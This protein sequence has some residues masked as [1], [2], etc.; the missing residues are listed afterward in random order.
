MHMAKIALDSRHHFAR[1]V[2]AGIAPARGDGVRLSGE[3]DPLRP[4]GERPQIASSD[5][6]VF[7]LANNV[8][9]WPRLL[10]FACDES[11]L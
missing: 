6:I 4:N 11:N 1:E 7:A 10:G 3:C 2:A 9:A 8:N 5:R